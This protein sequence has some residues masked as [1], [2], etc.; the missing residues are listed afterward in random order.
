M[1]AIEGYLAEPCL[2]AP[3]C[4][5]KALYGA[6]HRGVGPVGHG[7]ILHFSAFHALQQG[8]HA[9][10]EAALVGAYNLDALFVHL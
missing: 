7:A 3:R 10:V 8:L 5:I 1:S 6:T 9:I 2:M 4:A